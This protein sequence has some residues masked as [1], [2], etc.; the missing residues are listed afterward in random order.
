MRFQFVY[1]AQ[2]TDR[3]TSYRCFQ[4]STAPPD[5]ASCW[6]ARGLLWIS[7]PRTMKWSTLTVDPPNVGRTDDRLMAK[8]RRVGSAGHEKGGTWL[9]ALPSR[10]RHS[11]SVDPRE[12]LLSSVSS[13][14]HTP[15]TRHDPRRCCWRSGDQASVQAESRRMREC[16]QLGRDVGCVVDTA[17]T[18]S[19]LR[20]SSCAPTSLSNTL[21]ALNRLPTRSFLLRTRTYGSAHMSVSPVSVIE[22]WGTGGS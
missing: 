13:L 10:V 8:V 9:R 6:T 11:P 15:N 4:C 17:L 14:R 20:T 22:I 16:L 19:R 12:S 7:S 2:A 3:K 18:S 1:P 5:H 21:H